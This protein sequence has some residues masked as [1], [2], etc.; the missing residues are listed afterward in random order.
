MKLVARKRSLRRTSLD[1]IPEDDEAARFYQEVHG[2][3]YEKE[4]SAP[5]VSTL[6]LNLECDTNVHAS[7][8]EMCLNN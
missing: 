6:K 7:D 1:A 3:F 8:F 5:L 4:V 2:D